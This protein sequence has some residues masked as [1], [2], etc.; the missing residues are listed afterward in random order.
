VSTENGISIFSWCNDVRGVRDTYDKIAFSHDFLDAFEVAEFL[1]VPSELIE[2]IAED[3]IQGFY[4]LNELPK[5]FFTWPPRERNQYLAAVPGSTVPTL[6]WFMNE[7]CEYVN[8]SIAKESRVCG[9]AGTSWSPIS[10][11]LNDNPSLNEH[12]TVVQF[13]LDP[14][15]PKTFSLWKASEDTPLLVYDPEATGAVT[16]AR[17]LFGNYAFGGRTSDITEAKSSALRVPWADGYEALGLLDAN[18]DDKISG[19]ELSP[20][21]LWF[22]RDRD[23]ISDKGE[24]LTAQAFGI[25]ELFYK[26]AQKVSNTKDIE[27]AKG[28]TRV[29]DGKKSFGRSIDWYGES[30]ESEHEATQALGAQYRAARNTKDATTLLDTLPEQLRG[31][32]LTFKPG[33]AKDHAKDLSGYWLWSTKDASGTKRPGVFALKQQGDKVFGYNIVE[34]PLD[35]NEKGLRSSIRIIPAMGEISRSA[36]G[37]RMISMKLLDLTGKG[38][39]VSTVIVTQTG[40]SLQGRTK[41]EMISGKGDA[42]QSVSTEYE[43]SAVKFT[44][45]IKR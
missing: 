38:D 16:S 7:K 34:A 43:W 24:I 18:H 11:V 14:H 1:K 5:D 19:E 4:R 2:T 45:K 27:L 40:T 6:E 10:L 44:P 21:A 25:S 20:L 23:G 12:N 8:D 41:Q 3:Y 22:D 32:P 15:L 29:I 31:N 28:F 17:Q 13:P 30:F 39:A 33:Y 9:F 37:E 26:N 35:P 42:I 36:K